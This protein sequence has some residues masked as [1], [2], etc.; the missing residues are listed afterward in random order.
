M[1]FFIY[2]IAYQRIDAKDKRRCGTNAISGSDI[3]NVW[4]SYGTKHL[5]RGCI[6]NVASLG[7]SGV[8]IGAMHQRQPPHG[9]VVVFRLAL[10]DDLLGV[11]RARLDY[12]VGP[13]LR[14]VRLFSGGLI[15]RQMY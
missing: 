12:P 6:V 14:R 9:D 13:L 8:L 5:S 4:H 10:V 2:D 3:T 1:L 11:L 7:A 15:R